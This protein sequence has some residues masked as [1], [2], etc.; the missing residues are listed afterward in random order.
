MKCVQQNRYITSVLCD[1]IVIIRVYLR[2]NIFYTIKNS[3]QIPKVNKL[4]KS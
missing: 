4:H 2:F 3:S 1:P